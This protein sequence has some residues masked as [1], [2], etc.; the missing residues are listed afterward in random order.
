MPTP[1]MKISQENDTTGMLYALGAFLMWGMAPILFKELSHVPAMIF[2]ACRMILSFIFLLGLLFFM[3][4]LPT[5]LAEIRQIVTNWKL[6]MLI[7]LS[8]ALISS[9]WLVYIWAVANDNVLETSLG[10]FINPLMN[11]ALGM[12]ILGERLSRVKMLAVALAA[13]GVLYMLINGGRFPWVAFYLATSF[14]VYGLIRKKAVVGAVM[15]L[16]M[17]M[18]IL[19]PVAFSY[20]F[21]MNSS[22]QFDGGSFDDYTVLMLVISGFVTTIPLVLFSVAAKK[23]PL[24][25]LGILQY[26]APSMIFLLAIFLWHEPFTM[27]HMVTFG[28]IWGALVIYSVDSFFP[29]RRRS[30]VSD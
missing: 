17:E 19:L 28:C 12:V 30:K 15:G 4:T 25:T 22:G 29:S 5:F 1:N 10:Y 27:T 9:N 6:L 3:R 18:F 20:L 21:Y 7:F 23:L 16:W 8:S 14:A 26:I 2:L 24:S 13:V 11:I